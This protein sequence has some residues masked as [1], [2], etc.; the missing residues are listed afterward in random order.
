M[1]IFERI[2][3]QLYKRGHKFIPGLRPSLNGSYVL[4]YHNVEQQETPFINKLGIN[5]KPSDFEDHIRDLTSNYRLAPLSRI[6][7]ECIDNCAMAVTFDDGYRSILTTV[8]PIIE[9][10][11]CPIKIYLTT[12]HI[13]EGIGW[14]NQ[15]SYLFNKLTRDELRKLGEAALR[16]PAPFGKHTI[17][18]GDFIAWFDVDKTP[19]VIAETFAKQCHDP[20]PRLFLNEEEIQQLALHP[21]VELGSHSRSH[22]PLNRLGRKHL[23]E[24]VVENH[25]YLQRIFGDRIQG[26]CVPFGYRNQL[27]PEVVAAVLEVDSFIVSAYGG[28]LDAN[29][30]YGATEIK[31]IGVWGNLG[32]LWYRLRFA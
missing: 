22:Y 28:R 24:E 7:N 23:Y 18:V 29:K 11:Q 2:L 10:Y 17:T 3:F 13:Y 1:T 9:R 5:I 12:Q 14:L 16:A 8:L 19:Q 26:F 4:L 31:R 15:L 27:T 30:I 25:V 21:L 6:C 20:I 32:T